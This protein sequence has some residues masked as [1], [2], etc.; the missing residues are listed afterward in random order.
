MPITLSDLKSN[1]RTVP[2]E[3]DGETFA[4]TYRP[5]VV[6]PDFGVG[7]SRTYL[8]DSLLALLTAWDIYEDAAYTVMTP[9]TADVLNS[10]SI[11]LP[12]LRTMFDAIMQDVLPG[13]RNGATSSAG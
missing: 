9:I 13:K 10:D 4:L 6:T 7:E 1:T 5:S 8:V 11:G 3:Y 12:L 2:C